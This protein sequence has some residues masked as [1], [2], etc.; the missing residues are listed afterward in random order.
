MFEGNKAEIVESD[1]IQKSDTESSCV[2]CSEILRVSST[3]C[4]AIAE[5]IHSMFCVAW[6]R[7][8][9]TEPIQ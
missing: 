7:K 1:F 3:S 4:L 9:P 2:H 6:P 8:A 5:E